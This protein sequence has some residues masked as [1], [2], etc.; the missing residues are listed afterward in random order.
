MI[1]LVVAIDTVYAEIFVVCIFRGQAI[2]Q[3]LKSHG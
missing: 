3:D 1:R 2:D